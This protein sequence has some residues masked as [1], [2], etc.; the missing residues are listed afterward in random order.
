MNKE[1]ACTIKQKYP[2][3]REVHRAK[4]VNT[5]GISYKKGTILLP[6]CVEIMQF[7]L[8]EFH[9]FLVHFRVFEVNASHLIELVFAEHDK[10][11][12]DYPLVGIV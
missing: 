12:D 11:L 2:D 5:N 4:T 6:K 1:I 8:T 3:V 7:W 9:V 10:L